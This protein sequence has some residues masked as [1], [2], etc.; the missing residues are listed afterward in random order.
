MAVRRDPERG[1]TVVFTFKHA[2]GR[3]ERVRRTAPVQTKLAAEEF[4]RQ[5]RNEMLNPTRPTKE[6]LFEN[7]ATTFEKDYM[8]AELKLSTRMRYECAIRIHLVPEFGNRHLAD[9]SEELITRYKAKLV[10]AKWPNSTIRKTLGIVSRMLHVAKKWG[11][12]NVVPEFSF[13]R[14]PTPPFRYLT[15][16]ERSKILE[17]AGDYWYGP[18][19]FGLMTG[20][21][22]GEIFALTRE[23]LDL[24]NGIV[25]VNRAVYR[26]EVALPKHDK[27]RD[28]ELSPALV[29]FLRDHLK[30]VNLRTN[31][32]FPTREGG[33][34]QERKADT[35]L[36]R[37]AERAGVK[38]FGWHVLRHTFASHL[39]MKNVP[40]Q[41]VQQLLGHA[42]IKETERYAHLS[43]HMRRDAVVKLDELSGTRIGTEVEIRDTGVTQGLVG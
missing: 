36:R 23:Q 13:P 16:D 17:H 26:G 6:V 41:I 39:V 24:A 3:H 11:Y 28:I 10:E 32:V 12:L 9:I 25:H 14:V 20:C 33:I 22:M 31:L 42:S 30:V 35:G 27:T 1:W 2:D 37:T 29:A 18:I 5:L 43:P 21:R 4:E 38:P 34:R 40:L 7:F 8:M 19:Y 15:E